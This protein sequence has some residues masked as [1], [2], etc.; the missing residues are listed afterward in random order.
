MRGRKQHNNDDPRIETMRNGENENG[1][2]ND[3]IEQEK[4]K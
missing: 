3:G 2:Y 1:K 4:T